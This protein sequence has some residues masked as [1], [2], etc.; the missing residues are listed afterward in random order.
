MPELVSA[1]PGMISRLSG[2]NFVIQVVN[3]AFSGAEIAKIRGGLAKLN[4]LIGE[5]HAKSWITFGNSETRAEFAKLSAKECADSSLILTP[6]CLTML[7]P[8]CNVA[9]PN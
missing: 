1:I 2:F 8:P 7:Q 5:S 9:L 3:F 4:V 6:W